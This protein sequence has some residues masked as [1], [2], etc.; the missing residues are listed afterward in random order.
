MG[1]MRAGGT[2][3]KRGSLATR[4]SSARSAA[5]RAWLGSG[6]TACGLPSPATRPSWAFQRCR[7]RRSMPAISQARCSRAPALCATSMSRA[8]DWRSSRPIIRPLPLLKIAWTFFDSTSSAA[9]SARAR[10]LRSNSRSSSLMRLRSCRVACGLAR[11]SSGSA[12]AAV[13]LARHWS[14]SAGNTPCPRHQA[15][16]AASFIAA[17]VTTASSRAPAVQARSRAGLDCASARQR[18]SVAT[19]TPTSRATCSNP[20]LSGG[21]NRATARSLNACPYRATSVPL[22]PPRSGFYRGD[23]YSDAGGASYLRCPGP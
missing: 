5:L 6:R 21:S 23:N 11:A 15:L 4:S 7:V 8:R 12:S 9:V 20:A 16:L 13:Q 14:S 3:A 1:T 10:S 19:T 18:S 2:A 22:T 17:V